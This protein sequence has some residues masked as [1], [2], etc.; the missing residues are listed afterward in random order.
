MILQKSPG[1]EYTGHIVW[2]LLVGLTVA[3]LLIFAMVIKGIK[4][5][6]VIFQ[7]GFGYFYHLNTKV[8]GKLVYFTCT[9]PYFVLLVLGIRGW[10]L[11]GAAE[12]IK[13]YIYPDFSK[14]KNLDIWSD[15]AGGSHVL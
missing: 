10:L 13:F 7:F 9:Y 4:V 2:K 1:I 6:G 12:G 5:N 14:L 11:D 15:A 3:W 8:S